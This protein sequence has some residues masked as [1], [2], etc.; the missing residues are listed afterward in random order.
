MFLY[1]I[2]VNAVLFIIISATSYNRFLGSIPFKIARGSYGQ[3]LAKRLWVS[4]I[5]DEGASDVLRPGS[6]ERQVY[7]DSGT[8]SNQRG[9]WSKYSMNTL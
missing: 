9:T 2:Q 5:S 8:C 4:K 7:M 6:I 1:R 3:E